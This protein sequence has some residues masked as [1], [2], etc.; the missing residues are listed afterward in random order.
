MKK[1]LYGLLAVIVLLV[2]SAVLAPNFIDWNRYKPKI[3]AAVKSATGRELSIQGPID[4]SL[5]PT[6]KLSVSDARLANLE[7][8]SEPDMVRLGSLNVQ[9]ALMPL[10]TGEIQVESVTLVEPVLYLERLADGRVNWT[11]APTDQSAAEAAGESA[12][13]PAGD[14]SAPPFAISLDSVRIEDATIVYKDQ[15]AG[16]VQTI[17]GLT[18]DLSAETLQGPF[19]AA[20]TVTIR[21]I[22]VDF[23]VAFGSLGT[24]PIPARLAL[25][26][27]GGRVQFS[28][29][30]SIAG[31]AP[32]VKG[33]LT[34]DGENLKQVLADIVPPADA[35]AIPS[36][37]GQA[38]AVDAT[39]A[40]DGT[41][42]AVKPFEVR[43]G[44]SIAN[45]EVSASLGELTEVN[46]KLGVN[47]LDLDELLAAANGAAPAGASAPANPPSGPVDDDA[48]AAA[49]TAGFV[50]PANLKANA[51]INVDALTYNGNVVRQVIA[52]AEVGEGAIN[53][54]RVSALLPGGSDFTLFGLAEMVEGRPRF[55]GQVDAASDNLR[56][57]LDWLRIQVDGIPADRLRK[58]SLAADI[59]SWPDQGQISNIDLRLDAT[60]LAGGVAYV[61]KERP[62]FGINLSVDRL[63]L[64]A[65][66]PGLAA[67]D[68]AGG[69]GAGGGDADGAAA[70]AP[71][72][73]SAG[74]PLAVLDAFNADVKARADQLTF[75]GM[76]ITGVVLDG[77]LQNGK[78]TVRQASI[79]DVVGAKMSAS[80]EVQPLSATPSLN[81]NVDIDAKN[82]VDLARLAGVAD[83]LPAGVGGP[84][85]LTAGVDGTLDAF[86]VDGTVGVAGGKVTLNG[87]VVGGVP[88]PSLD[89]T[90]GID[91]PDLAALIETVTGKPAADAPKGMRAPVKVAAKLTGP[92]EKLQ[93]DGQ[94][95]LGET[96]LSVAGTIDGLP[97]AP[98][99]ALT[100]KLANPNL[101]GLLAGFDVGE[102]LAGLDGPLAVN[103]TISGSPTA[104]SIPELE[105]QLGE[106]KVTGSLAVDMAGERPKISA[107][108]VT[109]EIVVDRYLPNT[110]ASGGGAGGGGTKTGAAA[111]GA[112]A[113][114]TAPGAVP[115]T[116]D[117]LD[118]SGLKLVDADIK[119]ASDALLYQGYRF[120][121]A[122]LGLTIQDGVL[123]VDQ[124]SGKSF[125]GTIGLTA[126]VAASD[127]PTAEVNYKLD[128]ADVHRLLSETAGIDDITGRLSLDGALTTS[129]RSQYE[130]VSGLNGKGTITG[131][132]GTIAGLDL[133]RISDRLNELN[134]I[135]DFVTLADDA[136]SGGQTA[137]S[138]LHGTYSVEQ[139]VIAT[140]DMQLDA[141]G[142]VGKVDGR[143][144]LP[145]WR[146]ALDASFALTDHPKAPPIGIRLTGPVNA[147]EKQLQLEQMQTY[148]VGRGVSSVLENVLDDD[149][150]GVGKLIKGVIGGGGGGGGDGAQGQ[151]SLGEG[152]GKLLEGLTGG[153]SQPAEQAVPTTEPESAETAPAQEPAQPQTQ[154]PEDV[155]KNLLGDMLNG[156]R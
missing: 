42:V 112:T 17:E 13:V 114:E 72:P 116:H 44:K 68:E 40:V 132:E 14:S 27:A 101:A 23:D 118:L 107:D 110:E 31:E 59:V 30:V 69:T 102:K 111:G 145:R 61:I 70:P 8:A 33:K 129:G 146:L 98:N 39:V 37:M 41:D 105:A 80:G 64:D 82:A 134:N 122:K 150:K 99:F 108:L 106:S 49:R 103:G 83:S 56:A 12:E 29:T 65:Y 58:M 77:L 120:D 130:L 54:Q 115:W 73:A 125:D 16:T 84:L 51:E 86:K 57:V 79:E 62:A 43:L 127:P 26:R 55:T 5:L 149:Q 3:V 11:F 87:D 153:G 131:G 45:G 4:L 47:R 147:P 15:E 133:R 76:P 141:D 117:P 119:L 152:V 96:S 35:Q 142:G 9:V 90:A 104:V 94:G 123:M 6:P 121:E 71:A 126:K 32:A 10:F 36:G 91:Y 89:L 124:L 25:E 154:K 38:F 97:V 74:N 128:G 136:T 7:G 60:R 2:V 66:M 18:A 93:V 28:G 137:Y 21:D 75:R 34:M 143:V 140:S 113:G 19:T 24:D 92:L 52:V 63:N 135:A 20:G 138:G 100:S 144:D 148:L 95:S 67:S 139:G 155:L 53:L 109:G 156:G 48:D 85:T 88:T 78:L 22:P 151:P 50:I 46:L 1:L 81:A